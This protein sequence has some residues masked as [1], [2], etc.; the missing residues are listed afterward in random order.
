MVKLFGKKG[1]ETANFKFDASVKLKG[2]QPEEYSHVA[3][4]FQVAILRFERMLKESLLEG[5]ISSTTLEKVSQG[6][7]I[8]TVRDLSIPKIDSVKSLF[9][10]ESALIMARKSDSMKVE[11]PSPPSIPKEEKIPEIIPPTE[12][13]PAPEPVI[14]T[15]VEPVAPVV[16]VAEKPKISF[17]FPPSPPKSSPAATPPT[18]APDPIISPS[19]PSIPKISFTTE[20]K[21]SPPP[22]ANPLEAI[23]GRREEDRATGIAILRKQMLTELKK[24]RSVVA[25]QDQ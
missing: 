10:E 25:E 8:A 3:F 23:R 4:A 15:P 9:G 13:P 5:Y 18:K 11:T 20:P 24:I 16:E 6:F 14:E 7:K 12:I 19:K 2:L 22:P 17:S 21:P 1:K